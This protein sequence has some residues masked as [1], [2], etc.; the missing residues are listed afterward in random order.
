MFCKTDY[1]LDTNILLHLIRDS[2]LCRK[3]VDTYEL[4]EDLTNCAICV[5]TVGEIYAIARRRNWGKQKIDTMHTLLSHVEWIGI[6]YDNVFEAYAEVDYVSTSQQMG[7]NDMWIA[8]VA[9][10]TG[11]TLL[12]TDKAFNP[13]Y[14]KLISGYWIDPNTR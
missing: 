1:L 3:I 7:K 8:A 5:V 2:P 9:K 11:F 14:G 12:T 13:L 10:V 6:D 4:T